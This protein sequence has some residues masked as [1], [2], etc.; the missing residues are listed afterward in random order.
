MAYWL[1]KTEPDKDWSWDDQVKKG[2]EPWDAIRNYQARNNMQAMKKGDGAFF[3]HSG[4]DKCVMGIVTIVRLAY[5]DPADETGKFVLVDVKTGRAF[6][7][8]VT[9]FQIRAEPSLTEMVPV[10]N[11]R[12]SVQPVTA[13]EWKRVCAM[14]GVAP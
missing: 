14:G 12:P 4:K 6:A 10:K 11:S 8:P 3:Y 9:L 2:T 7:S 13:A 1:L 5:P